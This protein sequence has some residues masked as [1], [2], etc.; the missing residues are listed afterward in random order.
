VSKAEY[1]I[2]PVESLKK[3]AEFTFSE[4][5]N[6]LLNTFE[7]DGS[8][9][10]YELEPV[11][12]NL[13]YAGFF[14][15][16]AVSQDVEKSAEGVMGNGLGGGGP[17][18]NAPYRIVKVSINMP[19]LET[20]TNPYTR[21]ASI[22]SANRDFSV[23]IS[24]R[25]DVY[26][27]IQRYHYDWLNRWYDVRYDVLRCGIVGKYRRLSVIAYH[28]ATKQSK[29][30]ALDPPTPVPL[31]AVDIGG[32]MPENF[33]NITFDY[34][35]DG[36]DSFLEC[37]YRAS[38]IAWLYNSDVYKPDNSTIARPANVPSG[39]AATRSLSTAISDESLMWLTTYRNKGLY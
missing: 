9:Y 31:F 24:W 36:N 35:S 33:G 17:L 20:E 32:M 14:Y 26:R 4:G 2:D 10:I 6:E 7:W 5:I 15:E 25:D 34:N 19:T 22:K 30:Q 8:S 18:R 27:T 11:S 1:P 12:S 28:F 38:K 37:K 29:A 16:R 21:V 23:S 3:P 39:L 13:F